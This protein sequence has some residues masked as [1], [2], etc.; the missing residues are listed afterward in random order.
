MVM[1]KL[2]DWCDEASLVDWKQGSLPDWSEAEARMRNSGRTSRVRHPS[3]A[4]A[5]G[6]T[7]PA[8]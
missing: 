8:E 6:E 5:R 1:P 4:Q 3:P 7:V 2:L